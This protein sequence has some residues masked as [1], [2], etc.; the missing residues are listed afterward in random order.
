MIE[1]LIRELATGRAAAL[2]AMRPFDASL[3]LGRPE[4]FPLAREMPPETLGE[5]MRAYGITGGL[6]SHFDGRTRSPQRG[7][8]ELLA[9]PLP[10]GTYR[11]FTGLPL[12]PP[13]DGPLPGAG[14]LPEDVRAVRLFPR[15]HGYP[16]AGWILRTLVE[17]MIER[18]LPLFA[19]HVELQWPE[20]YS[21]AREYPRL[22][23]I[24][25]SQPRKIIYHTRPLLALMKACPNVHLEISNATGPLIGMALA[26]LGPDRLVY[27]S[28]L[29]ANDPLVPLGI[30]L[31]SGL[32]PADRRQVAG[33]NLRRL[34]EGGGR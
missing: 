8:A 24:V 14:D 32:S 17:W 4:G 18:G 28:F 15:T 30:L 11:A 25:E 3:W 7:N 20:L 9:A 12:F 2:P 26:Q 27:G 31:E 5:T 21:L 13:E 16:L 29:P 19:W 1:D 6:V 10:A 22:A 23:I 34:V 33:D